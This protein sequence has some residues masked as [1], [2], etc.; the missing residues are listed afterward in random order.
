MNVRSQIPDLTIIQS[1]QFFFS[2]H[3]FFVCFFVSFY[4]MVP[5]LIEACDMPIWII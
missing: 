3:T 1:T 2:V 5:K 4:L